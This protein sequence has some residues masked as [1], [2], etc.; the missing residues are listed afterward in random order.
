MST[1][2]FLETSLIGIRPRRCSPSSRLSRPQ[3]PPQVRDQRRHRRP[4]G[5]SQS[6]VGHFD[7]Q[8]VT[9]R[10]KNA[11]TDWSSR[12]RS[13]RSERPSKDGR[14]IFEVRSLR[15]RQPRPK[16][17]EDFGLL[18]NDESGLE[19]SFGFRNRNSGNGN[20]GSRSGSGH[21][22]RRRFRRKDEVQR[23]RHHRSRRK[24]RHLV[25]NYLIN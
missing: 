20:S 6:T 5:Q 25:I 8:S 23:H 1:G 19:R 14:R 15:H 4:P 13:R 11:A 2:V 9:R 16:R 21:D 24:C 22:E 7:R 18:W 3:R 12:R 10:P 17:E